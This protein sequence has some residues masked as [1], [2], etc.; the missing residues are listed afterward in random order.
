MSM[1]LHSIGALRIVSQH[2]GRAWLTVSQHQ[3]RA[4]LSV[5]EGW[6]DTSMRAPSSCLPASH[7]T[8]PP[9]HSPPPSFSSRET[10]LISFSSSPPWRRLISR[11][12]DLHWLRLLSLSSSLTNYL[13][14]TKNCA[15]TIT[16]IWSHSSS[17]SHTWSG[18]YKL[19]HPAILDRR[20]WKRW[21]TST[22][23][24]KKLYLW[25]K[26]LYLRIKTLSLSTIWFKTFYLMAFIV[27]VEKS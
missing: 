8:S 18:L 16:I 22:I 11:S 25:F 19:F 20:T 21:K 12:Y 7:S 23:W 6:A 4:M 27:T 9:P 26:T 2:Q 5:S 15:L 24:P 17:S 13:P 14:L 10:H 1:E 3:G